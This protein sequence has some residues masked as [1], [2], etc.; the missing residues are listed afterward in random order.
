[1]SQQ[2]PIVELRNVTKAYGNVNAVDDISFKV[3]SGEVVGLI[4]DNG[5]GKSTLIKL[6]SGVHAPSSG[7]IFIR[8]EKV[9]N[10]DSAKAR[11]SACW[12][13]RARKR[14]SRRW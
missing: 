7:E 9:Q 3:Y 4:G 10:W 12:V 14:G 11:S 6:L 5:A 2:T 8:G 13:S 1:M